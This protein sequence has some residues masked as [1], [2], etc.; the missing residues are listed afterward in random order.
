MHDQVT[1]EH[2]VNVCIHQLFEAQVAR[3]P[4]ATALVFEGEMLSYRELNARSN[5]L[6]HQLIALG[7]RP[8]QR[9][10][11]CVEC[12]PAMIVGLMAILKAGG[13]Y[14]PL[15][16]AN[17]GER[18]AFIL[19]DTA[20]VLVLADAAGRHALG[21]AL[22]AYTV[23]DPRDVHAKADANPGVIGLAPSHLA[24]IIY[25]SGST[26]QPKGVMV[27]HAQVAR[28]FDTTHPSF[29]FKASDIWCLFHSFAF[30]FSV[31]ELWGALRYGGTLVLVPRAIT[32]S[33]KAFYQLIC[34]QGVTVLNQTPSAFTALMEYVRP[35]SDR[36]RYVIFGGEALQPSTLRHWYDV[37]GESAPQLVNMYGITETTVHVTYYL[38]P[39]A[40]CHFWW[41]SAATVHPAPLV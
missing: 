7:V 34:E 22:Q 13:A 41:R 10:A 16:P 30:D 24:Y 29:G 23:L 15:D 3:S 1:S 40:L 26:G 20:P 8:D 31:W 37:R 14:V 33:P 39:A 32:R 11:I 36:L 21:A 17:S 19:G 5:R 9:V 35:S 12:S 38:R 6:A 18:L 25:T 28:L 27:E 4:E 2:S